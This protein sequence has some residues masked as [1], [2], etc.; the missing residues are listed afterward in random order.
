MQCKSLEIEER[1]GRLEGMADAYGNLGAIYRDRWDLEESE[2]MFRKSL[3]IE[4]RCTGSVPFR[5]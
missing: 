5:G 3:K 1:L 4:E 2:R